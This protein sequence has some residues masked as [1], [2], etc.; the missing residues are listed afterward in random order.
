VLDLCRGLLAYSVP[1]MPVVVPHAA[2]AQLVALA[3][4]GAVVE[5][6]P[7]EPL[8]RLHDVA[9]LGRRYNRA[10]ATVRQWFHDGLFGP[11]E[12]R[13]FRG[14]GYVASD[15]AVRVFEARTGLRPVAGEPTITALG[16][17]EPVEGG[18]H[19]TG[20]PALPVD[21]AA[22]EGRSE[23]P[24]VESPRRGRV[25]LR[26]GSALPVVAAASE[27]RSVVTRGVE[28]PRKGR[29]EG[30]RTQEAPTAKGRVGDQI[31]ALGAR[32]RAG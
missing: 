20:G 30:A 8:H 31:R 1:G 15:E 9:A 21:D 6:P 32:R 14:R 3:T 2:L 11:P 17:E 24:Q 18:P 23:V 22:S 16:T 29:V 19:V 28:S 25:G 26:T 13:L 10:R 4:G 7:A 27:G 12:E 5:D